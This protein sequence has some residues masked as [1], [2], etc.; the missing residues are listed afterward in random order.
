MSNSQELDHRL[1]TLF[2][3]SKSIYGKFN[4]KNFIMK[5]RILVIF[6][7]GLV[8]ALSFLFKDKILV[9]KE[10]YLNIKSNAQK[11]IKETQ[12]FEDYNNS[13][14]GVL[15]KDKDGIEY[16][17]DP[18]DS[19]ITGGF[20]VSSEW[21]AHLRN[22]LKQRIKP[23]NKVL[24][25]GAHQG[26]H[27]VLISHLVGNAGAVYAF[28]PNPRILPFTKAN[29][30]F[31][32]FKNVKLF[33]KAAYSSNTSLSFIS[34]D[35]YNNSGS[36]HI[37][38][39]NKSNDNIKMLGDEITVEAVKIDDIP[40]IQS[41]DFIQMD[42]EGAEPEAIKGAA[43]LINNSPNLTVFQEWSVSMMGKESA[44]QY[45]KFWRD[46][47]FKFAEIRCEN[48]TPKTD[49]ELLELG[50]TDI[51]IAKNLDE[52]ISDFKPCK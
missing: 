49:Q 13:L 29:I 24:C 48:L 18:R 30:Y 4:Q 45:L 40:E 12:I 23:G 39:A 9:S 43:K 15:F 2:L 33:E 14:T 10:K 26:V 5:N 28:E 46:L 42:I 32:P 38:G 37:I 22:I 3:H 11:Y 50:H 6:V 21:E 25:L 41:V 27:V 34:M 1:W 44:Q 51:I 20:I 47:G 35:P 36:S 8:G 17:L 52:I 31:D 16:F 7:V 19:W